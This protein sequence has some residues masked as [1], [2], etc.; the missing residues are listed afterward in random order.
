MSRS[1]N[2]SIGCLDLALIV[3]QALFVGLKLGKVID[4]SWGVVL[5]PL[6]IFLGIILLA[7]IVSEL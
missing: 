1:D 7:V 4:W 3:F 2:S 5:I 6:W